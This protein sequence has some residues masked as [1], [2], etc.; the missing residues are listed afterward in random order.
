MRITAI[1]AVVF[2]FNTMLAWLTMIHALTDSV[3]RPLGYAAL[4]GAAAFTSW[5]PAHISRA[6]QSASHE[7]VKPKSL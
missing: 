6:D 4:I 2:T 7:T 3:G 1:W 5:Y